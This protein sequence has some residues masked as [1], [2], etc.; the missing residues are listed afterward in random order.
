MHS[1]PG[2]KVSLH[3]QCVVTNS[4]WR[5]LIGQKHLIQ[6]LYYAVIAETPNCASKMIKTCRFI[7]VLLF[8]SIAIG[9][10]KNVGAKHDFDKDNDEA[11]LNTVKLAVQKLN[12]P[13]SCIKI[14]LISVD[15]ATRQIVSGYKYEWKMTVQLV[16]TGDDCDCGELCSS[17]DNTNTITGSA[18]VQSWKNVHDIQM[19]GTCVG[20]VPALKHLR[21]MLNCSEQPFTETQTPP[22]SPSPP[23]LSE[24]PKLLGGRSELTSEDHESLEFR[25]AVDKAIQELNRNSTCVQ[26]ELEKILEGTKQIVAGIK[27]QWGMRLKQ[28]WNDACD[29]DCESKECLRSPIREVT[30]EAI[31]QPWLRNS[32]IIS[33]T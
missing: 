33:L 19:V 1:H 7:L 14:Q 13:D 25:N 9:C 24:R 11:F 20:T 4:N 2:D 3:V 18:H 28:H 27:Y 22:P 12:S 10:K 6:L 31:S 26:Y 30:V 32:S 16:P 29:M 8:I 21:K 5:P 15:E 17:T 23:H